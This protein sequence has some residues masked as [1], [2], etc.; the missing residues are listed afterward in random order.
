MPHGKSSSKGLLLYSS[1]CQ[2]IKLTIHAKHNR[3][4]SLS[5]LSQH[6][7]AKSSLWQ[8]TTSKSISTT[9]MCMIYLMVLFAIYP[10]RNT[11]SSCGAQQ[12]GDA[13]VWSCV[14]G[15]TWGVSRVLFPVYPFLWSNSKLW[16]GKTGTGN[17]MHWLR[18][19]MNRGK[20]V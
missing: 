14:W 4:Y 2:V 9:V 17:K 10:R 8:Q 5:N 7:Q 6:A 15:C 16:E 19:R 11:G 12:L 18:H 1:Q 13:G 20:P 3:L